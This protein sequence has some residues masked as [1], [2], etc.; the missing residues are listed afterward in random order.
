[1]VAFF[2]D[3]SPVLIVSYRVLKMRPGCGVWRQPRDS[4]AYGHDCFVG[5]C[6]LLRPCLVSKYFPIFF[7]IPCHI[8]SL[9]ACME[10]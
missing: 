3:P 6:L 10:H 9:D 7:K 8:E 4:V 1:M 5:L 2:R